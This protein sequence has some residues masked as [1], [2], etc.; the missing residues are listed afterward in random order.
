MSDSARTGKTGEDIALLYL[1]K[2]GMRL[3]ERNYRVRGGEID[4]IM[5]D[6]GQIVFVEVKTRV[7]SGDGSAYDAVNAAKQRHITKAAVRYL[8]EKASFEAACRFDVVI[9]I[10]QPPDA[11]LE[12]HKNAFMPHTRF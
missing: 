12:H 5:D 6:G 8:S 3:L 10:G 9:I 1:E 7:Y 4:L 2:T 11:R